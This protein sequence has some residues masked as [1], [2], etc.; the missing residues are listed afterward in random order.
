MV[1]MHA[2]KRK[3]AFHELRSSRRK[4]AHFSNAECGVRN[5]ELRAG[6]RERNQDAAGL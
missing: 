3:G 5:A 2:E 1:P 4:E 6:V